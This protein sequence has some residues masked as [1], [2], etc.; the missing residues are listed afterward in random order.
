VQSTADLLQARGIEKPLDQESMLVTAAEVVFREDRRRWQRTGS[1]GSARSLYFVRTKDIGERLAKCLHCDFYH[2]RLN[3]ADRVSLL[4]AWCQATSSSCLVATSTLGAG[5]DYPSIRRIVH[6]DAPSGLVAYGQETG[7]AGR[8]GLHVI[9]LTILP[10]RWSV[11][12]DRRY[13][14]DFL[15]EDC[16]QA[17]EFLR[18]RHCL[19]QKLTLYLD[20]FL[21]GRYGI[22]CSERD[23]VERATCSNCNQPRQ[24]LALSQADRMQRLEQRGL[25]LSQAYRTQQD[26]SKDPSPIT[27]DSSDDPASDNEVST[28]VDIE[29]V[30]EISTPCSPVETA[31]AATTYDEDAWD[32]ATHMSRLA[33]MKNAEAQA[34]YEQ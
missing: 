19:R 34:L 17:E 29:P 7:R 13:R 24:G 27:S 33:T 9:C 18:S 16:A 25:D 21:G 12:W 4:T 26:K 2:A 20:G 31:T 22:A 5:F 30:E 14:S 1:Q 6:V 3:P 23:G 28:V 10:P 32:M 15:Q 8:D 11:D